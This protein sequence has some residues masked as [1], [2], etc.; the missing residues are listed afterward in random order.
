[1]TL[2]G[3]LLKELC[4]D[5]RMVPTTDGLLLNTGGR[6]TSDDDPFLAEANGQPPT[7]D[8]AGLTHGPGALGEPL[9]GR[10]LDRMPPE[11][12]DQMVIKPLPSVDGAMDPYTLGD[13][14]DRAG[15]AVQI[16]IGQLAPGRRLPE[17][18]DRMVPLDGNERTTTSDNATW[19]RVSPKN[20]RAVDAYDD[21]PADVAALWADQRY[22]SGQIVSG[23]DGT[24]LALPGGLAKSFY[25][26]AMTRF[27]RPL[28]GEDVA[29]A[30][31][32]GATTVPV[33]GYVE[34]L[35]QTESMP[36]SD[37]LVEVDDAAGNTRTFMAHVKVDDAAGT[38][39]ENL[40]HGAFLD[41]GA[42]D[43]AVF[44]VDRGEL[45]LT[46]MAGV[47]SVDDRFDELTDARLGPLAEPSWPMVWPKD[48]QVYRPVGGDVEIPV[49]GPLDGEPLPM[50]D[51]LATAAKE[52]GV[53]PV[54][55]GAHYSGG[56]LAV[57]RASER[58]NS[59]LEQYGWRGKVPLTV[60]RAGLKPDE[61]D[62]TSLLGVL[63]DRDAYLAHQVPA[64]AGGPSGTGGLT[65]NLGYHWTI[66]AKDAEPDELPPPSGQLTKEL[67][68][69]AATP[70]RPKYDQPPEQVAKF[71][72][73]PLRGPGD[74]Y[75]LHSPAVKE[76]APLLKPIAERDPA[77]AAHNA[78]VQLADLGHA[79]FVTSYLG[80]E[81]GQLAAIFKPMRDVGGDTAIDRAEGIRTLLPHLAALPGGDVGDLA[82]HGVLTAL[83]KGLAG[84]ATADQIR[85][86]IWQ[87]KDYLTKESK[88]DLVREIS[89]LKENLPEDQGSVDEVIK[90]I[91]TCPE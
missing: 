4:A 13:K 24:R 21:V 73:T 35:R 1:M 77:F 38:A 18:D 45:R 22:P 34:L 27:G 80:D 52:L 63:D 54:V 39:P 83:D 30:R 79:D 7:L 29:A 57:G 2:P 20:S 28:D 37:A 32:A 90:A 15:L 23:P 58:L 17:A 10:F 91:F 56:P 69:V 6:I 66:R 62:T 31:A 65:A 89:S 9:T 16:P 82:T 86:E 64:R 48:V 81:A 47:K 72:T 36:G 87:Y 41:P 44:P 71:L 75:D 51:K 43:G 5:G 33:R 84:T 55:L 68:K 19:V 70:R 67:L 88:V 50:L 12:A 61:E 8:I 11:A 59:L 85:D 3:A 26:D 49:I 40:L 76:L 25:G 60:T 53:Q 74:H 78:A 42:G 46:K 14:A